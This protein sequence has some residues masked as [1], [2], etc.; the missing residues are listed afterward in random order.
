MVKRSVVVDRACSAS[1]YGMLPA[2]P[3]NL[4]ITVAAL[5]ATSILSI[6]GFP[7]DMDTSR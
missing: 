4:P 3:V 7:Y 6:V 1:L 2:A 5:A